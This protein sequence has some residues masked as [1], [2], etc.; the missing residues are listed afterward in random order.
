MSR[1]R[2]RTIKPEMFE[3]E[4]IG[5][6]SRDARL[7]FVALITLAD[8]AGRCRGSAAH[9]RGQRYAYDE[10]VTPSMV[11]GWLRELCVAGLITVYVHEGQRYAHL[12]RWDRHQKVDRPSASK[13]PAPDGSCVFSSASPN[14]T[15]PREDSRDFVEASRT[16]DA[17]TSDRGPPT[18]DR[19]PWTS[20]R[21]PPTMELI[22]QDDTDKPFKVSKPKPSGPSGPSGPE[23][24]WLSAV[25]E[26]WNTHRG[27]RPAAEVPGPKTHRRDAKLLTLRDRFPDAGEWGDA[28]RALAE[29]DWHG[30][31]WVDGQNRLMSTL[32]W[33]LQDTKGSIELWHERGRAGRRDGWR[34]HQDPG[35]AYLSESDKLRRDALE[36]QRA[37]DIA[38]EFTLGPTQG[39]LVPIT[40]GRR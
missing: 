28:S 34:V 21:G 33:L 5:G 32:G 25:V 15:R 6:V 31:R 27:A 14:S 8:D 13:L 38:R 2:I 11:E 10:D 35:P 30:R 26:E 16:F 18:V 39:T 1:A 40:G 17:H 37:E 29:D 24:E 23:R 12:T 22:C 3:D 7:L 9:I 20:D 19:G 4:R 36:M